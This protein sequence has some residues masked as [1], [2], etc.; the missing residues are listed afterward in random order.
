MQL[1]RSELLQSPVEPVIHFRLPE[2]PLAADAETGQL[3]PL[4]QAVNSPR[5]ELEVLCQLLGR[6]EIGH[7]DAG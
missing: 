4:Q 6:K 7:R 1:R 2:A 3:V 5:R